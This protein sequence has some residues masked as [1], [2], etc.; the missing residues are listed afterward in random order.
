[1]V[2]LLHRLYG[3][4]GPECMSGVGLIS[5]ADIARFRH[6][7]IQPSSPVFRHLTRNVLLPVCFFQL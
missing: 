3:V 5:C 4:D 7:L 6:L 1:M 2:H